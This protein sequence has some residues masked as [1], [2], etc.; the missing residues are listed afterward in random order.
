MLSIEELAEL[1][2]IS[3]RNISLKLQI[4]EE[5]AK[6]Q[7]DDLGYVKTSDGFRR[8]NERGYRA[9]GDRDPEWLVE[10]DPHDEC[11]DN[12]DARIIACHQDGMKPKHISDLLRGARDLP[13]TPHKAAAVIRE[14]KKQQTVPT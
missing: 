12:L 13:V 7:L 1:P 9:R 6:A 11:G 8:A 5:E 3:L 4:T 2:G 14:F 10:H